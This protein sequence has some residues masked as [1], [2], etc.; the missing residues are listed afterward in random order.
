MT[1]RIKYYI[2]T[3]LMWSVAILCLSWEI[4]VKLFHR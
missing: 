3:G 1:A 4:Y 2:A